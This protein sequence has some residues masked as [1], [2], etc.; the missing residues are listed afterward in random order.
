MRLATS[1]PVLI[2]TLALTKILGRFSARLAGAPAYLLWFIPWT[3]PV[4]DRA[5]QKQAGWLEATQPFTVRTSVGRVAGYTAGDGPT[6]VLIHGLG[7][8]AAGLGGFIAPLTDAGFKVVALDLPAHGDS[9][10]QMANPIMW[11]TAVREVAGHFGGA[12]AIVAHSLGACAALWA[13]KDGLTA[14]RVVL[15]APTIDMASARDTFQVGFG[16]PP[17][18]MDGLKRKIERRYGP[19]IWR[20]L[21]G[22]HLVTF[23]DSRGLVIHDPDDPQVP[24]AASERLVRVWTGSKLI[25]APGLGH[26]PI[27]RDPAVIEQAVAFV[28]EPVRNLGM[29]RSG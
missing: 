24:F 13:T 11:A 12:H 9:S 29:T 3:A 20:D 17:K 27:T 15:L 28:A 18:A 23:I 6:V 22:E 21:S 7:D 10:G 5:L 26:G 14:Q 25:E 1:R 2:A 19:T 16:L 4:S 8:R